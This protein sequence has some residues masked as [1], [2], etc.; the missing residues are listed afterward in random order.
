MT[1]AERV[2]RAVTTLLVGVA[3]VAGC[4][5]PTSSPA[6]T[7]GPLPYDLAEPS[8][9][10]SSTVATTPTRGPQVY[11]VRDGVLVAASAAPGGSSTRDAVE[12]TLARLALGPSEPERAQR[13]STALGPDVSLEL[14]DLRDGLATVAVGSGPQP[15]GAGQLPLAVGQLVLTLTSL[16]DVDEV[17][18]SADGRAIAAPLPDGALTDRP[19]TARDYRGL[20][21][22]SS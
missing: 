5:A 20:T 4:G 15:P 14:V 2:L 8:P 16:P 12:R 21:T 3:V 7:V 10:A 18:L 6:T 17:L 1:R 19:L 11:F 22:P 13:L 9:S